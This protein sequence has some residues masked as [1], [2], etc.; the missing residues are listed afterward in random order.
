M[1]SVLIKEVQVINPGSRNQNALVDIWVKDGVIQNIGPNLSDN[2]VE[3]VIEAKGQSACPGF[4]D[5]NANFGEPGLET[6]EDLKSGANAALFGGF[7]GVAIH[8]NTEPA[9][10]TSSEIAY[11]VNKSKDLLPDI[12]PIGT[13]SKKQE[14][15]ELA[16]LFDMQSTGAIAFSDGHKSIQDASLMSK[17]LLYIKGVD[18]LLIAFPE[19]KTLSKGAFMNEGIVST[20]LGIKGKPNIAESLIVA[21]DLYL[22]EY[23]ET[24][25]HFTTISTKE[26]VELIRDAKKR[27]IRVTS[28]IAAHHLE[29][30]DETIKNF[31]SQY[32]VNPPLRTL[33]DQQALLEGLKDGTIDAICS[34][35]T[36]HEVEFK[37]VEFQI[38][39]DGIITLQTVLPSLIKAGLS[40]ETIVEKLAVKPRQ[41]LGL[42][43]PQIKVG[44]KANFILVDLNKKWTFTESLNL[45][46]S[47]NSPYFSRELTGKVSYVIKGSQVNNNN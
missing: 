18:S 32:K 16:E 10:H 9:L 35:H 2:A 7:T 20:Y 11:V 13:V 27:G 28:D 26:S 40:L 3:M 34:Q 8:P 21:R 33:E 29:F 47:K 39:S 46:K 22:A 25:I 30:L 17:A 12:Y 31:D 44:E 37:N 15:K 38:A 14:G 6:K 5:L 42:D 43:V 36:P 45:S 23:H 1:S 4:F 24:K 41:I 19:D